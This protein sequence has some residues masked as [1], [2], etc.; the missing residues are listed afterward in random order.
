MGF[1]KLKLLH[2][3]PRSKKYD[4]GSGIKDRGRLSERQLAF[5]KTY[6]LLNYEMR[7]SYCGLMRSANLC[8]SE[9]ESIAK[10]YDDFIF[11]SLRL[12]L[13]NELLR[14]KPIIITFVRLFSSIITNFFSFIFSFRLYKA[15]EPYNRK[16]FNLKNDNARVSESRVSKV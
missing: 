16:T 12:I 8:E 11:T 10:K 7:F 15:Y 4:K 3:I 5:T 6:R 13:V 14:F 2:Y 1:S 9:E